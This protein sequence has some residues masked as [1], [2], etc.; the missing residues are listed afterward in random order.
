MHTSGDADQ[1]VRLPRTRNPLVQVSPEDV[2][3]YAEKFRLQKG[4]RDDLPPDL[5]AKAVL[6]ARNPDAF[7]EFD[8]ELQEEFGQ[9]DL[10]ELE[11]TTLADLGNTRREDLVVLREERTHRWR[12]SLSLYGTIAMCSIG[13]A[14]Q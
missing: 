8:P 3:K 5:L 14:V 10:T 11:R 1:I 4:L 2:L 13:A 6:L 12:Q 9:P 7:L